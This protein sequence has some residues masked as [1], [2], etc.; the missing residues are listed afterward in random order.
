[1][2]VWL[3]L[4]QDE[5]VD[6]TG[7]L[8]AMLSDVGDEQPVERIFP[9]VSLRHYSLPENAFL[10]DQPPISHP[11]EFNFGDQ[12]RLLGYS[13]IDGRQ[14]LLFWEAMQPLDEDYKVS[15]VLRDTA[16]QSWGQWDGRPAAYLYP[17]DRWRVGQVVFGRYDLRSLPGTPPG[18][19]GLEVGVYAEEEPVGLDVLD[20]SGAP[21]GKRAMLGAV[22][23][24][25]PAVTADQMAIPNPGWSEAGD[26]LALL[27]WELDR[28]EAQP[29]DRMLLTLVWS[30]E[31]QPQGNNALRVLVTDVTGQT[32]DAGIF[33]PT[34]IWHPT[35][36]WLP[37]QAWRGQST[38]R[39]PIQM[40]PGEASLAVQ[41]VDA[42]GAPL[43]E[44]IDLT[45]L[46][47]SATTRVFTPPQPQAPRKTNFD[48]QVLLLGADLGPDPVQPGG[49]LRVALYWQALA[50][51]DIPYTVFVHLLGPDGEVLV[52][53]DSEPALGTRPTT[54]WVPG[55]YVADPH[56]LSLP[57]DLVSGEYV[58]E[59]GLYDAG[60]PG[61]PR[62]PV[63]GEEGQIETDRVIFGP[64]SVR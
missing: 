18:D 27:G 41:L 59:V 4:W 15:L 17:T 49:T 50:E 62:L 53:H 32:Y 9:K 55:E 1:D 23:L 64:V 47:V 20:P 33:S 21:Q 14:V 29:G 16:G 34:N 10:S 44:R 42:G 22:R 3:V 2:G 37:G 12:L 60:A 6:P 56:E 46:Q 43:G 48:N 11:A 35:A 54:G 45:P 5:V 31:S 25:V 58:I 39:L 13:Q 19:Y 57:A 63:V 51:M 28:S 8:T 7:Y 36:T 40:Q 52:G 24:A 26:G 30:V 61:M 38:F